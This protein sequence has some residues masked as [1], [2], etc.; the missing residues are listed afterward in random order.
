MQARKWVLARTQPC[1]HPG[2]GLPASR[3]AR[4]PWAAWAA[5]PAGLCDG[6]QVDRVDSLRAT[7]P[8][9]KPMVML[10]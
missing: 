1:R 10:P 7:A 2:L 4:N 5:Q 8:I 6:A 3:A 9:L